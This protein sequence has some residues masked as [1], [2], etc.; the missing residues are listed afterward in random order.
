M[1]FEQ[2]VSRY[3]TTDVEVVTADASLTEVA[4]RLSDRG[5]S[6]VPVV[7]ANG[8]I[9]GVVSRSDLLAAGRFEATAH[10]GRLALQ[11]PELRAIDLVSRR[12]HLC[13]SSTTLRQAGREMREYRIHRLFVVDD[14]KLNGVISTLDL[15]AAVRDEGPD[16]T[17]G[18]LMTSPVITIPVSATL[19]AAVRQLDRA[20][21]TA[22]VV[23]DERWP[24]GTFTQAEALA[25]RDLPESTPI[26]DL[27]DPSIICMPTSTRVHHAAAQAAQLDVRRVIACAD[28]EAVGIVTGLDFAAL[29]AGDLA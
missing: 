11:L 20:H 12:P 25:A 24:I 8:G 29:V 9:V 13:T 23:V 1:S 14:G 21:V 19:G 2:P 18:A 28:R 27:H 16:L 17:I 7:G 4:R 10:R 6:A 5:I 22:L 15:V 26:D 3:M